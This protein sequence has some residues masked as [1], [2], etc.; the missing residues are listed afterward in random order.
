MAPGF[1]RM[2]QI[3]IGTTSWRHTDSQNSH[4]KS[5]QF[6]PFF[7][8]ETRRETASF[9]PLSDS[10]AVARRVLT[11]VQPINN[12]KRQCWGFWT[13]F[14]HNLASD[15]AR[16]AHKKRISVKLILKNAGLALVSL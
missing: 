8:N 6:F 5:I 4:S 2:T 3:L 14:G 13:N 11:E 15:C 10:S 7:Q 9:E 12:T 1:F 16:E